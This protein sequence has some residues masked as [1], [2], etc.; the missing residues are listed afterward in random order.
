MC[1]AVGLTVTHGR[2][3]WL[4]LDPTPNRFDLFRGQWLAPDAA[5]LSVA[6]EL[7][8]QCFGPDLC[9]SAW[10]PSTRKTYAA[11]CALFAAFSERHGVEPLPLHPSVTVRWLDHLSD[12][13][14]GSS[15]N[16]ALCALLAW[17]KLNNLV[18]PLVSSPVIK[19]AW[20]GIRRTRM[21]RARPQ[22]APLS[23]TIILAIYQLYW[24]RFEFVDPID[25]LVETRTVGWLLLGFE[26]APRVA[27]LCNLTVCC[28]IPLL[29]GS[30]IIL[31]LEAKNNRDLAAC[32]SKVFIAPAMHHLRQFFRP[33]PRS[34]D[35]CT[36]P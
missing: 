17:S 1:C 16:L 13:L 30:A 6:A 36:Y 15:V 19:L 31:I 21:S 11:W 12:Y 3:S 7:T 27:E 8:A 26:I 24:K 23:E 18:D 20:Q 10:A 9:Q 14:S 5:R 32:L 25:C 2:R 33:L 4:L 22:K 35:W 29:D 34:C 28:Y